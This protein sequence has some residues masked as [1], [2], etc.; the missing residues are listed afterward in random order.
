MIICILLTAHKALVHGQTSKQARTIDFQFNLAPRNHRAQQNQDN[1]PT[2]GTYEA[3]PLTSSSTIPLTS[4]VIDARNEQEFPSLGNAPINIRP[5]VA[6][7]MRPSSS[8]LA[9]TKENFPALGGGN[10][11]IRDPFRQP[12]SAPTVN[13]STLL[14][15]TPAPKPV[16]NNKNNTKNKVKTLP[17]KASDFPALSH[18]ASS[19][20]GKKANLESDL[21]ET[22]VDFGGVSAKHRQLVPSYESSVASTVANQ[23]LKTIQRAEIKPVTAPANHV[24]LM[25]SKENFPT[26]GGPSPST[27]PAPQWLNATTNGNKKQTQI[28]KK[29]KIAPAPILPTTKFTDAQD[30]TKKS[31]LNEKSK[32]ATERKTENGK[33]DN[34]STKKTEKT[35]KKSDKEN[36]K[37]TKENNNLSTNG[38][39]SKSEKKSNSLPTTNNSINEPIN[40]YSSVAHFAMP[41]PG[42]PAKKSAEQSTKVPPGFE[43]LTN[44]S[45]KRYSYISP[46]NALLRNQVSQSFQKIENEFS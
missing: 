32:I 19:N 23:K 21:I 37:K 30:D 38:N 7:N 36:I 45:K 26:L 5:T 12:V 8:G 27:V 14:F 28:S 46:S 10:T 9:R 16:S 11:Q 42:F 22:P 15:K 13:A 3:V 31:K 40:S 17:N 25:N 44:N 33:G 29:L 2:N 34:T 43:N 4:R 6:L 20:K 41:P 24:P 35:N 18:S 39:Q 1:E